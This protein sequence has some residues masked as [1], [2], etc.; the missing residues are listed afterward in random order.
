MKRFPSILLLLAAMFFLAVPAHA[1]LVSVEVMW[2]CDEN[3]NPVN[4][5]GITETALNNTYNIQVGSIVQ[6]VAFNSHDDS[7]R[8][9]KE[10][11]PD[12]THY[13]TVG[14]QGYSGNFTPYGS[15]YLP[16]TT[17]AGHEIIGTGHVQDFG[18]GT[19]GLVMWVNLDYPY[20]SLYVRVFEATQFQQMV[21]TTS[22]W[23][24]TEV[25]NI[26]YHPLGTAFTW[27]DN[28]AATNLNS[29]ELIPEP[30]SLAFLFSG[31]CGMGVFALFRRRRSRPTEE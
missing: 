20:D 2:G 12:N 7:I 1:L 17:V 26:G 10:D 3:G 8:L 30:S 6:I 23:A 19:Y 15:D 13:T 18:N 28:V 31:G 21:S 29:F 14:D 27:F 24:I 16:N 22:H 25:T 11:D 4:G 5:V 9:P